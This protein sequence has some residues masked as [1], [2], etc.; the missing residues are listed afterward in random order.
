MN[1]RFS[2]GVVLLVLLGLANAAG[3][4][5]AAPPPAR[6]AAPWLLVSD[7][8]FDPFDD[9]ALDADLVRS[10]EGAWHGIFARSAAPPSGY[11]E[12][13][14]FALLEAALAA[15]RARTAE[16]AVVIVAGD[17]LAH[18]FPKRFAAVPGSSPAAYDGF[19]DKTIAFLAQELGTAFP[20][21]QF[22]VTLGNNDGYCDDYAGTPGSPFLA[23]MAAAFA[24]L[25]N[26]DGRAPDFVRDFSRAGYYSAELP[27]PAGAQILALD[28]VYW[29]AKYQNSCGVP[30]ADPGAQELAWL[31]AR[32][33]SRPAP[34]A[35]RWFLTHI[36]PAIDQYSSLRAGRPVPFL[37]EGAAHRLL[38]LTAAAR[39]ATFVFGHVHHA[40]F[41]IVGPGDGSGVPGLVVPS[42]SAVQGNDPAF[43]VADVSPAGIVSDFTTYALPLAEPGKAWTFEYDFDGAYGASAFTTPELVSLQARLAGDPAL[44][45]RYASYYNSGS[46]T[47]AVVP[48]TWPWYWCGDFE[49]ESAAYAACVSNLLPQGSQPNR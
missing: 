20:R 12:D 44:W 8:H 10:P 17:F 47:A 29:S 13:T 36:P 6:A 49:L 4:A 2:S 34:G 41:E 27:G 16:P 31:A 32:T 43:V 30:G 5:A 7:L 42:I 14:N 1:R 11:F 46:T 28:S 21:A 9:P 19:V 25:V 33:S 45:R 24:P 40:S 37:Q 22:V 38:A 15:M 23:H 18:E 3:V 39:P 35:C 48:A 26:R